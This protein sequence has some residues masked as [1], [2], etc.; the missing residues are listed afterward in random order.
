MNIHMSDQD[1]FQY[2]TTFEP[3]N[4]EDANK[5]LTC[6]EEYS[7]G[8]DFQSG[9]AYNRARRLFV[10]FPQLDNKK[11]LRLQQNDKQVQ[12]EIREGFWK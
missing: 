6:L 4:I 5:Y 8:G 12:N 7:K 11:L 1:W 2:I 3:E 9:I 10:S